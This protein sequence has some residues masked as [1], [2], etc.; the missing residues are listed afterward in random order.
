MLDK[1]NITLRVLLLLAVAML[2]VYFMPREK[3]FT[4][5]YSIGTPW[6][7]SRIIAE[8]DFPI[9]KS[10]EKVHAEYD[11]IIRHMHPLF[12]H[13]ESVSQVQVAKLKTKI[14]ESGNTAG[15]SILVKLLNDVYDKGVVSEHDYNRVSDS[16]L[17][18]SVVYDKGVSAQVISVSSLYSPRTAYEYIVHSMDSL[19]LS[20]E[21]LAN[22]DL[23]LYITP[24]LMMNEERTN[25]LRNDALKH[26]SSSSG[27][28]MSGEKII[29]RGEIV[30]AHTYEVLKSLEKET[31]KRD[32][33]NDSLL[34]M[35]GQ[36]LCVVILLS[37]FVVYLWLYR[38]DYIKSWQSVFFLLTLILL[39]SVAASYSLQ[40]NELNVYIVPFAIVP[41]FVRVFMDSRTAFATMLIIVSVC[42]LSLHNPYEFM[43]LEMVAGFVAIFSLKELTSRSQM[44]RSVTYITL[45]TAL[46]KLGY[47]LS[48]GFILSTIEA[49][50]YM[51]IAANGLLLLFA[52]PL[53]LLFEKI[54]GMVSSVTLVELSNVN[55]PL[56]RQMSKEAQGTFNHSMQVANLATE[57]AAKIGADVQLVRTAALY[58]D[59]G[60]LKNP[61]FFTE[62]QADINPHDKLKETQSAQI[63]IQ[64]VTYG[65]ELA[66]K[67]RL[68]AVI[69]DCIATHHGCGK[70]RFFYINYVKNNPDVEVNESLFSYPGPNPHTKE[71]AIL[72][73]TDAVEAASRSLKEIN[74]ES[75]RK[76]VDNIIEQQTKDGFF[77]DCPITFADITVA[78]DVLVTCLKTIYHTRISYPKFDDDDKEAPVVAASSPLAAN[79]PTLATNASTLATNSSSVV[80]TPTMATETGQSVNAIGQSANAIGQSANAIGQSANTIGQSANAIGQS[81]NTIG[82]SANA[83]VTPGQPETATPPSDGAEA[84]RP[85]IKL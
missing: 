81:A 1:K 43:L 23:N 70:T 55:T 29:D 26:L 53:M 68:P 56:L 57:V 34:L 54:F 66:N 4:Y 33:G 79:S 46:T 10:E 38:S 8:Y 62:N 64:H 59:I 49:S 78:K 28:V 52:Y 47:D 21:W 7:Y 75:L 67:Y 11:S 20:R 22:N 48:Q 35:L 17:N 30:T 63:V 32:S 61:V 3:H 82:Q 83:T 85:G 41:I 51:R 73:M 58:H 12:D 19:Q 65:L 40:T 13:N 44:I 60:K 50:W 39:F 71:Q 69:K 37:V 5:N 84:E 77:R 72:M 36:Y 18:I 42:S 45:V 74:E 16:V 27:M 2:I 80:T 25:S 76:L 15:A 9:Y 31:D 14:A 24:N 6:K